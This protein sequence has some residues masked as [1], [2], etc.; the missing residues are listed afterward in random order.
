MCSLK[1]E[2]FPRLEK[3]V[4][5]KWAPVFLSPLIGS[6]ERLVIGVVAAN[7]SDCHVERANA[8][9]RFE[10][11]YGAAAE[12]A[13]F[14]ADVA[15]DELEADVV[16][17]GM[18]ALVQPRPT[19]SGVSVG[20]VREGEALSLADI[21]RTW[22]A[23]LSSLH[24]SVAS[25]AFEAEVAPDMGTIK[26]GRSGDKLP[27]QVLAYVVGKRPGFENFFNSEIQGS[28]RR[29]RQSDVHNAVIDFAGSRLVANFGTLRSRT[30]AYSVD[31]IKRR[32]FDLM[33]ARDR[34]KAS[35]FHRTY[36]MI[37]QREGEKD[38]PIKPRQAATVS[39]TIV[40]LHEQARVEDISLRAMMNVSAIGEHILQAE[41][42]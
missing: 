22:I 36:E 6:P 31:R 30:R 18:E 26:D 39:E 10:C 2:H 9:F 38:Q 17:R 27:S 28:R 15:L 37:V 23:S 7:E 25:L 1:S 24:D 35:A 20:E 33:V 8:L 12:T 4:R 3:P 42:A 11:L 13:I 14:A 5:G 40:A 32:M 16:E 41:A 21:A 29:R 34:E 19:F